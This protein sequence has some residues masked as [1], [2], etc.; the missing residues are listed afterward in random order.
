MTAEYNKLG[1]KFLYPENWKLTEESDIGVADSESSDEN[2]GRIISLE[3]PDGGATWAVH[4]YP[5]E[6]DGDIVL[7]ELLASLQE[8]YEDLEIAQDRLELG[9]QEAV[10]VEALFYCLDFLVRAQ[11][12]TIKTSEHLLLF[13]SQAEDRAFDEQKIVFQAISISVLRSMA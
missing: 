10:G 7:K 6:T 12:H 13:W 8:T 9:D 11:I 2:S 1:L 5:A 4:V 3:T